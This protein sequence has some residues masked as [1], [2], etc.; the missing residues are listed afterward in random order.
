MVVCIQ[1]GD[2]DDDDD[3]DIS[4]LPFVVW[5]LSNRFK[6]LNGDQR[7]HKKSKRFRTDSISNNDVVLQRSK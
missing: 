2:D 1:E 7:K 6:L 5:N 3:D 4:E